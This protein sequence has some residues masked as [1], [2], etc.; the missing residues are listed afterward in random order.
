MIREGGGYDFVGFSDNKWGERID[1]LIGIV[2]EI[3]D[4]YMMRCVMGFGWRM[5]VSIVVSIVVVVI[6]FMVFVLMVVVCKLDCEMFFYEIGV[7][8]C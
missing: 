7:V 6:V 3:G 8:L 4:L 2:W 5:F 1:L